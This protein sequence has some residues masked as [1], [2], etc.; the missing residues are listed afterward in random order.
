VS[1]ETFGK[2]RAAFDDEEIV[3]LTMVTSV[4]NMVS[5]TLNA[6]EIELEPST[7]RDLA[8]IGVELSY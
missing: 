8:E 7:A 4:Y 3:E 5:R 2:I 6:L 1:D